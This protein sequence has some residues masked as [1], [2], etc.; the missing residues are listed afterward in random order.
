[1][2]GTPAAIA[3]EVEEWL[4]SD[5]CDGFIVMFPYLPGR[6]EDFVNKIVPE[7][8]RP[9]IFRTEYEARR[10]GRISACHGQRVSFLSYFS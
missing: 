7:L 10:Y 6:L 2:I 5:A 4:L 3:A 1:M 9:G 8:Q